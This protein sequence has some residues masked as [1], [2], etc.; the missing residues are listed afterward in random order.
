MAPPL[1]P[2]TMDVALEPEAEQAA[3][4]KP[5]SGGF[6]LSPARRVSL[7][8]CGKVPSLTPLKIEEED[9][10]LSSTS[11]RVGHEY[12]CSYIPEYR[13]CQQASGENA[14]TTTTTSSQEPKKLSPLSPKKQR[15]TKEEREA[16]FLGLHLF[17]K[18]FRSV[19]KLITSKSVGKVVQHYY[20]DFKY[21]FA[22]RCWREASVKWGIKGEQFVS[23]RKQNKL[24]L[25][26]IARAKLGKRQGEKLY[27]CARQFNEGD[28]PLEKF[29]L[30]VADIA[31][32]DNL[33]EEVDLSAFGHQGE[34]F[35]GDSAA[36][37][38]ELLSFTLGL[39]PR[40]RHKIFWAHIWAPLAEQGWKYS[41]QQGAAYAKGEDKDVFSRKR[42]SFE[43]IPAFLKHLDE[44]VDLPAFHIPEDVKMH[45]ELQRGPTRSTGT[46][47]GGGGGGRS[48]STRTYPNADGK[49][50]TNCA[51]TSTPLWRKDRTNNDAILCNA[52]GIYLKNHGKHRPVAPKKEKVEQDA[53]P[54]A[55]SDIKEVNEEE[56]RNVQVVQSQASSG[57]NDGSRGD[58]NGDDQDVGASEASDASDQ[59]KFVEMPHWESR[60]TRGAN[61]KGLRA[62]TGS[63]SS[64]NESGGDA[65][66][67]FAMPSPR[68]ADPEVANAAQQLMS[69]HSLDWE[70]AQ[71][72]KRAV[73]AEARQGK[74]ERQSKS[75]SSGKSSKAAVNCANCHTTTTPLWRKDRETGDT[76]CNACGIYKK[77]HGK[78]RPV[79][80]TGQP[81]FLQ[82]K[83]D[84]SRSVMN[85]NEGGSQKRK[86]GDAA[87][88]RSQRRKVKQKK[89]KVADIN[90]KLID[91]SKGRSLF[92]DAAL[93]RN[94][95]IV[96]S[97]SQDS[98]MSS[99]NSEIV[100][101][102]AH[103]ASI[104]RIILV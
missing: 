23:G 67:V 20:D 95:E 77:N 35:V 24:M 100:S 78:V 17:G 73:P 50:C 80:K 21:T 58:G 38:K 5:Q 86:A 88:S 99:Q 53:S 52:C 49:V 29:V 41:G 64:S 33:V 12:Q 104:P 40:L 55:S 69:M 34:K 3:T 71:L 48:G 19:Q 46:R 13:G 8:K 7:G 84:K 76:L 39:N 72:E 22:Y 36:S 62:R 97:N 68:K 14:T 11:S 96:G 42:Q 56:M 28:L 2:T 83:E 16:F 9:K 32:R 30:E 37:S 85:V 10:G 51:T 31:G 27:D 6:L 15:W 89:A 61:R 59:D 75:S 4:T 54:N 81:K 90:Q 79:D 82:A 103:Q 18:E 47:V 74:K 45:F 98:G 66:V 1:E 101:S 43:G 60:R 65:A 102:F 63:P 26:L 93:E 57:A 25:G 91:P 70:S 92:A 87:G 94:D 44:N